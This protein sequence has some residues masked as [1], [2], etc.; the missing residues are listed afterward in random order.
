MPIALTTSSSIATSTTDGTAETV[1]SYTSD[2][3]LS[4][5]S[6][7]DSSD[8][9]M[10]LGGEATAIG[11]DTLAIGSLEATLDATGSTTSAYGSATFVAAAESEGDG[12]AFATA[13]SYGFVSGMDI[14]MVTTSNSEFVQEGP[15][16]SLWVATSETTLYGVDFDSLSM[17]GSADSGVPPPDQGLDTTDDLAV[18]DFAGSDSETDDLEVS[19]LSIGGLS[20][21]VTDHLDDDW[22]D[23]DGNVALLDV[24]ADV[25][26]SDTLLLV[27]A[28]V[29]SIEDA[30]STVVADLLAA[31]G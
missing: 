17:D 11:E 3:S 15:D 20:D 12:T 22:I 5:S 23:I 16:G 1:D 21:S 18:D 10:E 29:L 2:S 31:V 26:G 8:V 6:V 13:Q 7:P 27:A 30:L 19:D 9:V 25:L 24:D 14:L 4:F 28:D